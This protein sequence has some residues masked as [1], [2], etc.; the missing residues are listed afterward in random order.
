[1]SDG[2]DVS[3]NPAPGPDDVATQYMRDM[4][5]AGEQPPSPASDDLRRSGQ[6]GGRDADM[7]DGVVPTFA[8][9]ASTARTYRRSLFRR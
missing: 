4:R 5:G 2:F 9:P 7:G 1:M 3:R 8:Q 6:G